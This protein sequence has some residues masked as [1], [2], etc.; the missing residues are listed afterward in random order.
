MPFTGDLR[1][2]LTTTGR[3]PVA[4]I[5]RLR[6][7]GTP[8]LRPLT[9]AETVALLFGCAPF[10]N[11]DPFRR[12]RLLENIEACARDLPADE[13]T[14]P[15]R[16]RVLASGFS[17][18]GLVRS[19]GTLRPKSDVRFRRVAGEGV[20]LRQDEDEVLALNEVGARILEHI[21]EGI[22]V[23]DIVDRLL[24]EFD[25]E[26]AELEADTTEFVRELLK[27]V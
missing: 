2:D 18:E 15:L 17:R 10:I 9:D 22:T 8:R 13:L 12:G 5:F 6:Q 1:G 3:F 16:W 24:E 26:R 20:V 23:S 4:R 11:S 21:G 14:F 19:P 25:A 27:V 7:G